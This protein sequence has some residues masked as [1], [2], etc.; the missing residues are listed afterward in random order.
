MVFGWATVVSLSTVSLAPY[1]LYAVALF[2]L[3]LI[4]TVVYVR[5]LR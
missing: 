4:A 3:G 1:W 5:V 2:G